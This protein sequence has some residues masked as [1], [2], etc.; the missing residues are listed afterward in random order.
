MCRL[1]WLGLTLWNDKRE[2]AEGVL[3]NCF[4]SHSFP[5]V[6][7]SFLVGS[8]L[9]KT[10]LRTTSVT[11]VVGRCKAKGSVAGRRSTTTGDF[12]PSQ[13]R[14]R[15]SQVHRYSRCENG[16]ERS[17]LRVHVATPNASVDVDKALEKEL[18]ENGFRSTRRTKLICTI[19]PATSGY[20]ELEQLASNGMNVARLNM[21]HGSREWHKE[22]RLIQA[23][24]H[25]LIELSFSPPR[26]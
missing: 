17:D 18:Q 9:K 23:H 10:M 7:L 1:T 24:T 8:V 26:F 2:R 21:C 5:L 12:N 20:E 3:F 15:S 22:V 11:S 19:G 6:D 14:L 16:R 13:C 4:T 25:G